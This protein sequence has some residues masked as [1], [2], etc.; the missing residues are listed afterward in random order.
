MEIQGWR[1]L[2]EPYQ[3]AVDEIIVKLNH[4]IHQY[5]KRGQYSPMEQVS[6]RV[7]SISSILDKMQKKQIPFEEIRTR[8]EDISGIRI[9]CQFEEDIQKVVDLISARADMQIKTQKDY[10]LNEK[11]S[12]YRSYHMIVYYDVHT[13]DGLHRIPVEF[14]IRTLAMNFWATIEHSLQ[15]KYKHNLPA[16]ISE[17]LKN[18]SKAVLALDAEMATI[19]EEILDAQNSFHRKENVVADILNNIQNLYKVANKREIVK[20]QDEFYR[21][22]ATDDLESLAQFSKELDLISEGYRSQSLR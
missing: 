2:L 11:D 7:K 4:I 22:Y 21:I 8:I 5:R 1:E 6:G 13:L 9:I 15:Y 18:A 19:R 12:G 20:I 10:V 16:P 14:Q 17:K 3:L